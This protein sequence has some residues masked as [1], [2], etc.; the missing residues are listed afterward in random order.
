MEDVAMRTY[1]FTPFSRS[2]IGFERLFDRL[3]NMQWADNNDSYPPYDIVR[4]GEDSFRISLALA[5]FS[6]DDLSVT[7]Q[8]NLLT[9]TGRKP[10]QPGQD[11]LYQGISARP[12]ERRF[13][14]ADYI[15]VESAAFVNG[16]LQI[17]LV[18]RV[19]DAVKPRRIDI[20]SVATLPRRKQTTDHK[21]A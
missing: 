12:F 20:N 19:P 10:E 5:G 4:T 7:S 6:N 17:D 13:E 15:E 21:V 3:N 11:Y 16:L 2:T 18:R 1:D 9:V 8:Q 14:L